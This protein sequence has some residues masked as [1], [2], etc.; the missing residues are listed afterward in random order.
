MRESKKKDGG[1][2][3]MENDILIEKMK[4]LEKEMFL[5]KTMLNEPGI[6]NDLE[7]KKEIDKQIT[8]ARHNWWLLDSQVICPS[9]SK[10]I[11]NLMNSLFHQAFL[12]VFKYAIWVKSKH[13]IGNLSLDDIKEAE[14]NIKWIQE[15]DDNVYE[16]VL[17]EKENVEKGAYTFNMVCYVKKVNPHRYIKFVQNL[18]KMKLEKIQ[19]IFELYNSEILRIL[20]ENEEEKQSHLFLGNPYLQKLPFSENRLYR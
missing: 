13:K 15:D 9:D 6:E 12:S 19:E 3:T 10:G 8:K 2:L 5:Y 16:P 18:S 11:L 20:Y 17:N 1:T 14:E 4:D 7:R